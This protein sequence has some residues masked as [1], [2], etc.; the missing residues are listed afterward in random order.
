MGQEAT[1]EERGEEREQGKWR[2]N[3]K[4]KIILKNQK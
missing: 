2:R 3:K 4:E 1:D